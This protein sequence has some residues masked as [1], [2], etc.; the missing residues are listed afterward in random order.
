MLLFISTLL[1]GG[2]SPAMRHP[3]LIAGEAGLSEICSLNVN[4]YFIFE[5][6]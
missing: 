2:A 1:G 5:K 6:I 4:I 3:C